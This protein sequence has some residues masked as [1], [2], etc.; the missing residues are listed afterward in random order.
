VIRKLSI[1]LAVLAAAAVAAFSVTGGAQGSG[2]KA[3]AGDLTGAGSTFVAKL[4]QAWILKA[5]SALGVHVTYGPIGSGGGINAITNRTVDFGASDAPLTP[6]EFSAC[7]GCVQIPWALSAT[8][9]PY[10]LDGMNKQLRLTGSVLADIFL[11]KITRWND[12]RLSK[13]NKGANLPNEQITV[14]H[15]SDSSGTSYNLSDYLS[16][17]SPTGG[18]AS[19]AGRP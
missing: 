2:S 9:I 11:G 1:P 7:K 5:Q 17:V 10:H 12:P 13:I 4:V 6:D 3:S 8:S 16:K 19:D 14:I 15:R 18:R